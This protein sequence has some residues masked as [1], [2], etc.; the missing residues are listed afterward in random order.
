MTGRQLRLL[1]CEFNDKYFGGRLPAYHIRVMGRSTWLGESGR[2]FQKRR[3]IEVSRSLGRNDAISCL[4]HEMAHAVTSG[5]HGNSWKNEMIR[6]RE[7]RAPLIG[8]DA[9]V[10]MEDWDGM[11]VT[12]RH[13]SVVVNDAL[14]D[15]PTLTLSQAIKSFISTQG[16][17]TTIHKF[18]QKYPWTADLFRRLRKQHNETLKRTEALRKEL[19]S[20]RL[21]SL[22]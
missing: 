20:K 3:L 1:F 4:L 15:M 13:F 6:L 18:R 22:K 21:P 17:P 2:C 11:R 19:S 12:Q 10:R 8:P 9:N 5:H 14:I 7:A 16:G